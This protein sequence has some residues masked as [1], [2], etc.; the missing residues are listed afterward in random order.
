MSYKKIAELEQAIAK[1]NE[2]IAGVS[3]RM[4][5]QTKHIEQVQ[6]AQKKFQDHINRWQ[7][8]NLRDEKAIDHLR[9]DQAV[10]D[11]IKSFPD[12]SIAE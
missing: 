9:Y 7:S 6:K 2:K 1:R 12:T 4:E 3:A 5:R 8:Q 10:N 11:G